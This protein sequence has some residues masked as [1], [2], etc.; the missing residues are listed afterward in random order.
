MGPDPDFTPPGGIYLPPLFIGPVPDFVP[1]PGIP[2]GPR[3]CSPPHAIPEPPTMVHVFIFLCLVW[4]FSRI[5]RGGHCYG[6]LRNSH[7]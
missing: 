7:K 6:S 2:L 3:P 4:A 5:I 1:T